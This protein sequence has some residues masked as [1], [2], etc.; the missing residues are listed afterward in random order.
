MGLIGE[1]T[2]RRTYTL[3]WLPEAAVRPLQIG[4]H[5]DVIGTLTPEA[6]LRADITLQMQRKFHFPRFAADLNAQCIGFRDCLLAVG[7]SGEFIR[8]G[9]PIPRIKFLTNE[10]CWQCKGN[11]N[12]VRNSMPCLTCGGTGKECE[13]KRAELEAILATLIVLFQLCRASTLMPA[14]SSPLNVQLMDIDMMAMTGDQHQY[15]VALLESRLI[16]TFMRLDDGV[17]AVL[18]A[19]KNAWLMLMGP[20]DLHLRPGSDLKAQLYPERKA[21]AL[22][23]PGGCLFY[24]NNSRIQRDMGCEYSAMG[25]QCLEDLLVLLVGLASVHTQCDEARVAAA[26]AAV[27]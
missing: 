3:F 2:A 22:E 15:L 5:R 7:E 21:F 6:I 9:V 20:E 1:S 23:C 4:I 19:M 25:A 26:T 12:T 16:D 14:S 13:Y 18:K 27:L 11:K 24:Q 8:F 17:A 10:T